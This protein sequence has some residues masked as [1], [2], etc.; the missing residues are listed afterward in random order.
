MN[1]KRQ[2]DPF[3]VSGDPYSQYETALDELGETIEQQEQEQSA[4]GRER[5][6]AL[7]SLG[8]AGPR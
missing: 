6:A 7:R 4:D 1:R 8:L 2:A 5:H 3:R